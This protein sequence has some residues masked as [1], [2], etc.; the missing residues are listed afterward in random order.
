[1]GSSLKKSELIALAAEVSK[2]ECLLC[3]HKGKLVRVVDEV[4]IAITAATA[5]EVLILQDC[6]K[7]AKLLTAGL[8]GARLHPGQDCLELLLQVIDQSSPWEV[9]NIRVPQGR[10]DVSE[11]VCNTDYS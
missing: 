8:P 9:E 4:L 10:L 5:G 11:R 7:K 6:E 2:G 3:L 1:M